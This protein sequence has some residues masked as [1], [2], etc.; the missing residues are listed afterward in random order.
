MFCVCT[1]YF[2]TQYLHMISHTREKYGEHDCIFFSCL[3]KKHVFSRTRGEY[4]EIYYFLVYECCRVLIY[5]AVEVEKVEEMLITIILSEMKPIQCTL[6]RIRNLFNCFNR[7]CS[8]TE[9]EKRKNNKDLH[10]IRT[11]ES[12]VETDI[13]EKSKE[14]IDQILFILE[15]W[16]LSTNMFR[17]RQTDGQIDR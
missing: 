1:F 2:I 16:I 11:K 7:K 8:V 13:P 3:R 6:V 12:R 17:C 4:G 10:H 5:N 15:F 9:K 14:L